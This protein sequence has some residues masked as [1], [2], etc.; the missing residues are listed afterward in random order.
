L[1]SK[2]KREKEKEKEWLK[3]EQYLF[4]IMP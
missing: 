1:R 3:D 4:K 2:N